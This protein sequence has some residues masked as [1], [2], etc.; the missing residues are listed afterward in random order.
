MHKKDYERTGYNWGSNKRYTDSGTT[1]Y[2]HGDYGPSRG[3]A[4]DAIGRWYLK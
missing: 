1:I 3:I 2:T 4:V